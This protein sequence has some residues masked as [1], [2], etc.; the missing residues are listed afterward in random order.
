MAG[1]EAFHD[2]PGLRKH[3]NYRIR[4]GC[5]Y[6][7]QVAATEGK[8]SVFRRTKKVFFSP[9]TSMF[10]KSGDRGERKSFEMSPRYPT[11]TNRR[12]NVSVVASN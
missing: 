5:C 1:C 11:L 3:S 2:R 4:G 12:T 8:K 10:G 7:I 9:A 6:D